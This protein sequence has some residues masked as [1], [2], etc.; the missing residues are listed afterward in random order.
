MY[1]DPEYAY[2]K[3][4][5]EKKLNKVS[6]MIVKEDLDLKVIDKL[7][8]KHDNLEKELKELWK[9]ERDE[10]ESEKR[11][12]R[13]ITGLLSHVRLLLVIVAAILVYKL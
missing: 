7:T 12:H 6:E 13:D 5:L 3:K 10:Y 8:D 11:K 9:L 1:I 2:R 4:T